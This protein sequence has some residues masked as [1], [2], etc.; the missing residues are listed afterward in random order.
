MRTGEPIDA[1]KN[2]KD[3]GSTACGCWIYCGVTRM[4]RTRPR[5]ASRAAS[6]VGSR[7][8]GA[9]RGP[10]TAGSST[11]AR[12]PIPTAS[13]G[14][15]RRPTSGGTRTAGSGPA[16]TCP[17]SSRSVVRTTADAGVARARHDRRRRAVPHGGRRP[18]LALTRRPASSTDRSHAL[19]AAGVGPRGTR[20][21]GSSAI[22]CAGEFRRPG[23]P[24][25]RRARRPAIPVRAH[26]VPTHRA[27]HRWRH[28]PP[29]PWLTEL[30]PELFCEVSP[31]LA[32]DAGSSTADWATIQSARAEI[33]CR[34]MV[35]DDPSARDRRPDDPSSRRAVPL[36]TR[37]AHARR[38]RE[39]PLPVRDRSQRVHPESKVITVDVRPG[40][41]PPRSRTSR[42]RE[43][44]S[45]R[46]AAI[47][48]T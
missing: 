31:E 18:R 9:G 26:H 35:T 20:S 30:Q 45:T 44:R 13:P 29:A 15:R 19:R 5:D 41:R 43:R 40:R 48:R 21:T 22:R 38:Q 1:F 37:R 25:P 24:V 14:A 46:R 39:R 23:Q 33:E 47:Y 2:L 8:S 42:S 32:A 27:P 36:G 16:T 12:P 34:V 11:T 4:G 7:R 3:D 10:R 6:R 17:T 28:E